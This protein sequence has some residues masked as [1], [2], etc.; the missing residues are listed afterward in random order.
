MNK[1]GH[2]RAGA[3]TFA[4]LVFLAGCRSQSEVPPPAPVPKSPAPDFDAEIARASELKRPMLVLITESGK[5]GAEDSAQRLLDSSNLGSNTDRIVS[6]LL[7]L[8]VSRNRATAARFHVVETP[9]L[10]CLSPKGVIVSRDEK[11]LTKDLVLK[12]IDEVGPQAVELDAKLAMLEDPVIKNATDAK[13]Q[14][15]LADFL[16]GQ[17]NKREAIPHLALVARSDTADPAPRIRAWVDLAR[18]HL[19][20][21]EPEKARHEAEALIAVWG[22]KAPD[23]RAGGKLVLGSQDAKANR[24]ALARREFEEAIAAAPDSVY[25]RQASDELARLPKEEK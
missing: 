21:A 22:P 24:T 3:A 17:Q 11:P 6:V 20:I 10:L 15:A 16:Q 5:S 18:A 23:A 19:W 8:R 13:A 25:A 7:D 4:M 2:L 12:R 14:L 1:Q 9:V